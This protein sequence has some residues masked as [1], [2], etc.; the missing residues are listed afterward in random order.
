MDVNLIKFG[1]NIAEVEYA[2]QTVS[3]AEH[4]EQ[5]VDAPEPKSSVD[6]SK[7]I[8]FSADTLIEQQES[9]AID[10]AVEDALSQINDFVQSKSRQL[11]FSVDDDSGRQ[12]IKVTD[13][14]SGDIIRQ[15]PTEDVLKLSARIQEL[16]SDVG[17]SVGLFFDNRV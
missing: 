8:S 6:K 2:S 12:V 5:K 10:R 11:N 4:L 9:E 17:S 15:I 14:S 13:A 3:K 1:Q 16:Q 7:G